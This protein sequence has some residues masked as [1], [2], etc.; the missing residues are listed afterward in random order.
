[1]KYMITVICCAMIAACGVQRDLI[2]PSDIP[3]AQEQERQ[4]R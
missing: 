2:R 1:M 4:D 3:R